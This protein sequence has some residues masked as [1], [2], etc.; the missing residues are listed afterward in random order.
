MNQKTNNR[1][2]T[3]QMTEK[4]VRRDEQDRRIHF[5]ATHSIKETLKSLNTTLGGLGEKEIASSRFANGNNKITTKRRSRWPSVWPA[6]L[7]IPS[8]ESCSVWRLCRRSQI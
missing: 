7:S 1:A 6:H 5:A 4:M 8:P 3:R 2:Q